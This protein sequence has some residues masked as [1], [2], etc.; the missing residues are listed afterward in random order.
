[1]PIAVEEPFHVVGGPGTAAADC[2]YASPPPQCGARLGRNS[3]E[4][5]AMQRQA[6]QPQ[7]GRQAPPR[8]GSFS[9]RLM[10]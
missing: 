8:P 3:R 7:A 6:C 4:A 5:T 10:D 2:C 1:M 9:E